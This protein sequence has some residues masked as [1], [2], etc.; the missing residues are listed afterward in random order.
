MSYR[1]VCLCSDVKKNNLIYGAKLY[2]PNGCKAIYRSTAGWNKFR[3]IEE[4]DP[5]T[6]GVNAMKGDSGEAAGTAFY[7]LDGKR[8]QQ[9][10]HGVN[11]VRMSDGTVRKVFVK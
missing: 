3:Y 9:K 4:F 6:L 5:E 10:Q 11:I 2:V 1:W 7:T 8:L